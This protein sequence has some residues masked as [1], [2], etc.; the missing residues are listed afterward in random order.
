MITV[1]PSAGTVVQRF[2]LNAVHSLV[3]YRTKTP[4]ICKSL[5]KPSFLTTQCGNVLYL[6]DPEQVVILQSQYCIRCF[7]FV[8]NCYLLNEFCRMRLRNEKNSKELFCY[9]DKLYN[10]HRVHK[11]HCEKILYYVFFINHV[12]RFSLFILGF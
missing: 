11:F 3:I 2:L 5:I 7:D 6:T 12:I 8:F 1:S 4:L 9:D 10:T